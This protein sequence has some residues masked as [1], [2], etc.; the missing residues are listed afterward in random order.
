MDILGTVLT[1]F[2]VGKAKFDAAAVTAQRVL[3]L[4]DATGTVALLTT[5]LPIGATIGASADLN[6]YTS[7]GIFHQSSN[8][9]ALGGTNYPIPYAG[10]LMVYTQ[11]AMTYQ[12][13]HGYSGLAGSDKRFTR[14]LYN[15]T[16]SAWFETYTSGSL[17]T[18]LAQHNGASSSSGSLRML[19]PVDAYFATTTSSLT[20]ALRIAL[21]VGRYAYNTMLRMRVE[22]WDYG[23]NESI[24]L[25]IAGY[26]TTAHAWS[27]ETATILSGNTAKNFAVRFGNDGT[28]GCIWIGELA[29]T[30]AYVKFHVA[31][32]QVSYGG[33]SSPASEWMAGWS[34][35][36]EAAFDTVEDTI[37]GNFPIAQGLVTSP[38]ITTPILVTPSTNNL[39]L[40]NTASAD[41]N[42]LDNY[43]EGTFTVTV[44]GNTS[45]GVGTYI[46]RAGKYTRVG[47]RV[48]FSA[49][50]AW[51]AHTG[52]GS[53]VLTLPIAGS[54]GG[55]GGEALSVILTDIVFTG[56]PGAFIGS[57]TQVYFCDSL[58]NSAVAYLQLEAAGQVQV[59]GHY[60]I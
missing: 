43:E 8:A 33:D 58:S 32:I 21:P 20:G 46:G 19:F 29:S 27:M 16:W 4:P 59:S 10:K 35:T 7:T 13:Y 40:T 38:T 15:S 5:A 49:I 23:L 14:S 26:I 36:V 28:R 54:G 25:W 42:T 31:E 51:S 39:K 56:I 1:S 55:G 3:T 11:G 12:E 44:A 22:V 30:W 37:S 34:L 48:Y 50:V 9:N 6:T 45:A 47:D 53:M 17:L 2:K 41:P 24:S 18:T 60:S 52:T 57:A